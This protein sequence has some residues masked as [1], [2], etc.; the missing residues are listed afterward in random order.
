MEYKAQALFASSRRLL[1]ALCAPIRTVQGL[2]GHSDMRTMMI[3]THVLNR[4]G[5]RLY[6][7]TESVFPLTVLISVMPTPTGWN[8]NE[9]LNTPISRREFYYEMLVV[10]LFLVLIATSVIGADSTWRDLLLPLGALVMLSLHAIAIRKGT[11]R[12][13]AT[14]DPAA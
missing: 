10:W 13:R 3:Y 5:A 2:L 6:D 4:G 7:L 12:E 8:M 1:A 11:R 14:G 9:P